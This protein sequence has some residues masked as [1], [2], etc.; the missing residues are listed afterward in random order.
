MYVDDGAP[1]TPAHLSE[2]IVT[3]IELVY[4]ELQVQGPHELMQPY[5]AFRDDDGHV[6]YVTAVAF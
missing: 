1:R 6:L 5:Y 4:L 3:G 2:L